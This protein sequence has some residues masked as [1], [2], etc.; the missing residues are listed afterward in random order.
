[1][2][3]SA[4]VLLR[5]LHEHFARKDYVDPKVWDIT[6]VNWQEVLQLP[7]FP[8]EVRRIVDCMPECIP[9]EVRATLFQQTVKADEQRNQHQ[10]KVQVKVRRQMLFEDGFAAFMKVPDLKQIVGVVFVNELGQ[11]EEG[12]D[13]GGLFKEF[14]VDLAK[15]VFDPHYGLF[16]QTEKERELY[17]NAQSELLFSH[18]S[19]AKKAQRQDLQYYLFLGRLLG[20]A[21]YEGITLEPRFADFFLRRLIGKNNSLNDLK[22]LDPEL[23][24]QLSMMR[25]YEGEVEDLML[26]F[27]VTDENEVT[28]E[29]REVELIP[30]GAQINV[31]NKNK[32][33]YIY[34][35][36][37][38]R[39]N[40]RIKAQTDAFIRGFHEVIPLQWLAIFNEREMQ[41]LISGAQQRLNVADLKKH[42]KYIGGYSSSSSVVKQFWTILE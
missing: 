2:L 41:M 29:R 6:E 3:Y 31:T 42:T 39:L 27:C 32:F 30:G 38:F 13:A 15:I 36:A 9:F 35:V 33:R 19:A 37:D 12:R 25:S 11:Q 21:M 34:M 26:T 22:S 8:A 40:R 14:L 5:L 1:M 18:G 16:L 28:G 17:P 24:K 23:F 10:N 20:K 4:S 7:A